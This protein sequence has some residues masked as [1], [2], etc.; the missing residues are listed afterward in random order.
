MEEEDPVEKRKVEVLSKALVR[1]VVQG[2]L[3][4]RVTCD[5]RVME[6]VGA[7]VHE[8]LRALASESG[9]LC[10]ADKKKVIQPEHVSK[11]LRLLE[12]RA[13]ADAVDAELAELKSSPA[14]RKRRRP[15][16]PK[17]PAE[18]LERAQQA[19]FDAARAAGS[20]HE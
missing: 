11:A 20:A 2:C 17:L 6:A 16:G 19:L 5:A 1:A 8:F 10:D 14:S 3:P 12:F 9:A 13:Y 7:C 4:A 15:A 18:E